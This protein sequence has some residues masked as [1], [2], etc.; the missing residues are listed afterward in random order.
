MDMN[1]YAPLQR[2]FLFGPTQSGKDWLIRGF[3]K[4]V[5]QT[6]LNDRLSFYYRLQEVIDEEVLIAAEVFPPINIP[7]LCDRMISDMSL[8]EAKDKKNEEYRFSHYIVVYNNKG[9]NLINA[10]LDP[11]NNLHDF[12]WRSYEIL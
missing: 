5:E 10:L 11:D 12:N 1:S 3:A 9:D 8:Q 4:E 7:E 2:I 6:N